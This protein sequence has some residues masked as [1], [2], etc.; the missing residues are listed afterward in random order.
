MD[1]Q[2]WTRIE[3]IRRNAWCSIT[4]CPIRTEY[5]YST[6]WSSYGLSLLT[7]EGDAS[8]AL[9]AVRR[10]A[11]DY[12]AKESLNESMLERV[13]R[14]GIER[15]RLNKELYRS[16]ADLKESEQRFSE[17]ATHID[18]GLWIWSADSE[19]C[20]YQNPANDRIH[21]RTLDEMNGIN[22]FDV[23]HPDDREAEIRRASHSKATKTEYESRF[24]VVHPN[25][26]VVHVEQNC[27]PL[28]DDNGEIVRILG[29]CRDI[30]RR[31]ELEEELRLAQKLEAAG[32]LSAGVAH[33]IN[34]PCQYVSDNTEFLAHSFEDLLPVLKGFGELL[35]WARSSGMDASEY[36]RLSALAD[37]ADLPYLLDEMPSAL[38]QSRDGLD[39]IKKSFVR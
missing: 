16:L 7:N 4:R 23:I 6:S 26:D 35:D 20:V 15:D 37:K 36:G 24:R 39:Q 25:G 33:E 27:F 5:E 3:R 9:D 12:L 11:Q 31:V 19:H 2:A 38:Q 18:H 28:L 21:G 30:T 10:G 22:W 34:T 8:D 14:Y 1:E 17:L 13:I 32:Q 29:I